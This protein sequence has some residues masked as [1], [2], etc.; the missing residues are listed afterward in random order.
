MR[1][2]A[3]VI[4]IFSF[5]LVLALCL[6]YTQILRYPYYA[7]LARNNAIRIIPI[8][9]PRGNMFDRNGELLVG[10]RLSFN[11]AVVYQEIR[12]Q[13]KLV[14]ALSQS[15]GIPEGDVID[16]LETAR[17]KPYAP[18]TIV[19]DVPKDK[20]IMLEEASFDVPGLVIETRS[21]R[22]YVMGRSG[23]HIFG[24]LSEITEDELEKLR[25]YGYRMRD[26][27]GRG[28][29]EKYYNKDLTGTDGGVQ[30]EVDSRGRQVR[31]LGMKE[32]QCGTDIRLTLD[33]TLQAASDKLLGDR[34]GAVVVM[35][36]R[37]GEILALASHPSFDPSVFARPNTS[38]QRVKLLRDKVG[39]PLVNRAISGMYPLGSV[40]KIVTLSAA[41]QSHGITP[42]STYFCSGVY[43]LG[44]A[45]FRCWKD[46]GHGPQAATTGMMNSCDVY[47]YSIGRAAGPDN[48]ETFARMFGYGSRTGIDLPD[49][50]K[51]LVPGKQWK[52]QKKNEQ[53]YEGDTANYSI[54]QGFFLSTPL[55]AV[56]MMSVIANGGNLIVPHLI[57]K[58][59]DS[60]IPC[61]QAKSIGLK[62]TVR[63]KVR[64]G[65][66][67]VVNDEGGTGKNARVKGAVVAGKTGTAEN[68]QGRTHAWFSGYA[69][70]DN[71]KIC[72]VVFL[73][74]GGHGGLEPATIA[75]GIFEEAK[76]KGYF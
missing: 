57:K 54:G 48:I 19:E 45:R 21:I 76:K 13:T 62:E 70:Y 7:R 9:G 51:G 73:E 3:I 24:Y 15:L 2:R 22:D 58:I 5:F 14:N 31:T 71:P 33:K 37:N 1:D 32:P 59:G 56:T 25:D 16:A 53:W 10:S 40:F 36:P 35:D 29:L 18:A 69:P 28:G 60:D 12:S 72:L 63:Q 30:I 68:P 26:M 67:K 65:I 41:L 44:R 66:Y 75:K 6:F 61:P 64:E 34:K 52:R 43:S 38:A 17:R 39:K 20:A 74:H 8:D 42:L 49:E 55:Q 4:S 11:V 46:G 23:S 27:I 50:A 47:F